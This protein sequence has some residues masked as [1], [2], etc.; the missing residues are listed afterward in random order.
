MALPAS[1][2][3]NRADSSTT[4]GVNWTVR[5]G[6]PFGIFSNE[7]YQPGGAAV[8]AVEWTADSFNADHYAQAVCGPTFFSAQEISP[9]VRIQSNGDCYA[10][11][12]GKIIKIIGG[13]RSAVSA[14]GGSFTNADVVKLTATGTTLELF[15]NGVSLGTITDATLS[16]GGAGIFGAAANV[17]VDDF[18]ADNVGGGG[19]GGGNPWYYYA[20]EQLVR[21]S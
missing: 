5:V 12:F 4:L 1:D 6:G 13:V 19:G 14:F 21:E 17:T 20:N 8:A 16:G 9:A 7:C 2:N 10:V 15:K 3:F 18:L 11:Y